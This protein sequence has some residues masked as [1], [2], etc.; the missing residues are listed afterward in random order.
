MEKPTRRAPDPNFDWDAAPKKVR[1]GPRAA[2]PARTPP[3]DDDQDEVVLDPE[4]GLPPDPDP[5]VVAE[6]ARLTD[7]ERA[8]PYPDYFIADWNLMRRR[9]TDAPPA[10]GK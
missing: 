10:D 3:P 2:K 9:A 5:E 6:M 7:T 8:S 1:R 4:T